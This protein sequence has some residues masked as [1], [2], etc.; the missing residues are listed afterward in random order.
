MKKP[1][2][3]LV[4]LIAVVALLGLATVALGYS[5]RSLNAY[6]SDTGSATE[7]SVRHISASLHPLALPADDADDE[8]WGDF[9]CDIRVTDVAL[10]ILA[11]LLAAGG[12]W[13][14]IQLRR[15]VTA[16]RDAAV[17]AKESAAATRELIERIDR[18]G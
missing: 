12:L 11:F 8:W 10:V 13:Q 1:L 7:S 2:S 18:R 3:L 9:L 15:A 17:A 4:S 14:G 5:M 6:C 16:A